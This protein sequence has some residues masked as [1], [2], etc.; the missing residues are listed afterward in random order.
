MVSCSFKSLRIFLRNSRFF[1]N[2]SII[3]ISGSS[4][5]IFFYIQMAKQFKIIFSMIF[6]LNQQHFVP[7]LPN[8]KHKYFYIFPPYSNS[9]ADLLRLV[10]L[11]IEACM[12]LKRTEN[13]EDIGH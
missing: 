10:Y 13:S 6:N 4:F 2:R 11:I 3:E 7:S 8:V 5:I 9:L 1:V 12:I